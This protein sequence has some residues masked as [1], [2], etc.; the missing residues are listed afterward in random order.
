MY[1]KWHFYASKE[2]CFN[3]PPIAPLLKATA[4]ST[5]EGYPSEEEGG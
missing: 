5:L 2:A 3:S 4:M 1:K